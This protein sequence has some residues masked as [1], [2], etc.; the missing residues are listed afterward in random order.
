MNLKKCL[1]PTKYDAPIL[2]LIGWKAHEALAETQ[3]PAW[4]IAQALWI[5]LLYCVLRVV[6]DVVAGKLKSKKS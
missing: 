1:A 4:A 6:F 3:A 5:W 2:G